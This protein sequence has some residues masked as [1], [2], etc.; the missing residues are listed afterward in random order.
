MG[1]NGD[2]TGALRILISAGRI[3]HSVRVVEEIVIMECLEFG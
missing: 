3:F 1:T 2:T